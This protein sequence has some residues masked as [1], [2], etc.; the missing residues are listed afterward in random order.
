M[1]CGYLIA[2]VGPCKSQPS[3]DSSC[4][5]DKHKDKVCASCGAPA[6][7]ECDTTGQ[8]V[9]GAPLCN[10][11]E[12]TIAEDGTNGGVGFV[13]LSPLP[14]GYK[15]HCKK[16]EQKFTPWFMRPLSES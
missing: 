9:C 13:Q 16:T 12:H 14:P 7:Q 3:D 1:E 2:W 10:D 11:C 6:T 4:R 15:P 8:F 5:C